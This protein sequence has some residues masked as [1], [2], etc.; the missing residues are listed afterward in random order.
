MS[1]SHVDY[2]SMKYN[3][4]RIELRVLVAYTCETPKFSPSTA[5]PSLF[6]ALLGRALEAAEH[7]QD[8]PTLNYAWGPPPL[9]GLIPLTHIGSEDWS[10]REGVL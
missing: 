4:S 8:Q 7:H 2:F 3:G 9:W 10:H 1:R 5:W 6:P